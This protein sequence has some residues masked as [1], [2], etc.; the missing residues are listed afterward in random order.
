MMRN[1]LQHRNWVSKML[2]RVA[3]GA[4]ALAPVLALAIITTQPALAQTFTTLVNFDGTNGE[5]PEYASLVQGFD[6]NL[7]GTTEFGG[8]NGDGTV[9][10]ITTGGTLTTLYSFCSQG[11]PYCPDGAQPY[12][13]LVLATNGNF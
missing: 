6:G 2:L 3:S 7:Y 10:K 11:L 8:A 12:G 9:F 13:A 5:S 4:L 1:V